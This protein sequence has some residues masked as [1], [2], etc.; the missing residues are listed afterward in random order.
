MFQT[1]SRRLPPQPH[2][3][4]LLCQLFYRNVTYYIKNLVSVYV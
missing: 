3:E 2:V 4:H 1:F